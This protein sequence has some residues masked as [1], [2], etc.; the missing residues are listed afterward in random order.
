MTTIQQVIDRILQDIPDAPLP[1]TVDTFKSGDPTQE[2]KGIVTTFLASYAVIEQAVALGANLIITHEPTFYSHLD[3]VDWLEN[4]AVYRAKRQLL[5]DNGIVVWRFHDHIHRHE[6]DGIASGVMQ[7]LGWEEAWTDRELPVVQ[8]PP[9]TIRALA[10]HLKTRLGAQTVRVIGDLERMVERVCIF[11]GAAPGEWHIAFLSE[12]EDVDV[13]VAGEINE[14]E[15]VEYVR[16]AIAQGRQLAL[17]VVGHA[18]SEEPGM[19]WLVPWLQERLP[20][21]PIT[22]VPVGDPFQ[23]V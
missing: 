19:A 5:E 18:N 13:M 11:V 21:L 9:M 16:D 6:P 7:A 15:T 22:H 14:W 23:F 4:S 10:E 12:H 2:V 3:T 17:I 20:G 8:V 1:D